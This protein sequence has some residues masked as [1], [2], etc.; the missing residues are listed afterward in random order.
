MIVKNEED[1]I[2]KCLD[3]ALPHVD[4]IILVDT[5]STDRTIQI[6]STYTNQIYYYTW[7]GN[8]SAARNYGLE[9]ASGIWIIYLDSDEVLESDSQ[10]PLKEWLRTRNNDA[11]FS[12]K[13]V[14]YTGQHITEEETYHWSQTRIFRNGLGLKFRYVIHEMLN[15][16]EVV[17]VED[18]NMDIKESP[19]TIKHYG[20]LNN[21][22]TSKEKHKRNSQI[23]KQALDNK[24]SHPWLE[25]HLANEFYQTKQYRTAINTINTS[26]L[27]FITMGQVPPSLL[28]K[29]KYASIIASGD[30]D[31]AWPG[32]DKATELYPDYVDLH[33]YK[34]LIFSHKKMYLEAILSF[35]HCIQMGET[36]HTHLTE[37]G[38]GSFKSWFNIGLCYIQMGALEEAERALSRSLT[39]K[40][41]Y[42][43]AR[44]A[45]SHLKKELLK[46]EGTGS[47][48]V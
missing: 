4:E 28:Y 8:F 46:D 2:K 48:P 19:F 25:Y 10:I 31:S 3:S 33:F 6:A 41:M 9:Q 11:L 36:N 23:L 43:P 5:G 27:R 45:I 35:E 34:G 22:I 17:L 13:I 40:G 42:L 30:L 44:D 16:E 29:L 21:N 20:Y 24:E 15:L 26:I 18:L 32:I 39:T 7:D 47:S 38:T 1:T 37:F 12:I 14:N